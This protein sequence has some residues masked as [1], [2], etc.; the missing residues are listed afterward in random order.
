[1]GT[2]QVSIINISLEIMHTKIALNYSIL[3]TV[4]TIT[5]NKI[6]LIKPGKVLHSSKVS[7]FFVDTF[8]ECNTFI[9]QCFQGKQ[10]VPKKTKKREKCN[11]GETHFFY[12][13]LLLN[14]FN[15]QYWS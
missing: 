14:M 5:I 11:L 8:D 4:A 12:L 2:N 3:V 10:P 15:M 1:M 6:F 9:L 13:V 7:T